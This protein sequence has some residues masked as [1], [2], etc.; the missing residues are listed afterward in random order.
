MDMSIEKIC[1]RPIKLGPKDSGG[2]GGHMEEYEFS[3][4][5]LDRYQAAENVLGLHRLYKDK[6]TPETTMT[7]GSDSE[8]N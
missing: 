6:L 1:F 4:E 8:N 3:G 7:D 5:Q 2:F